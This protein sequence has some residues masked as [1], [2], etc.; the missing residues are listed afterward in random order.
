MLDLCECP[1][2]C[3]INLSI[4][5]LTGGA[6]SND[7]IPILGPVIQVFCVQLTEVYEYFQTY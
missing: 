7:L 3:H 1:D 4:Y 6:I 5:I 2:N